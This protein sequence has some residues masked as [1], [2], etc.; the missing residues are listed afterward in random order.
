M[1]I[2]TDRILYDKGPYH[3][4]IRIFLSSTFCDLQEERSVI[5]NKV[6]T[7]LN[8]R[9][10]DKGIK[11]IIVDLRWGVTDEAARNG[12]VIEICLSEIQ[13]S[14]PYFAAIIGGRYGW[15]PTEDEIRHN[16]SLCRLYPNVLEDVRN[17]RSITE[18]EIQYAFLKDNLLER[19]CVFFF[20]ELDCV[21]DNYK[22]SGKTLEHLLNL[23]ASIATKAKDRLCTVDT[24]KTPETLRDIFYKRVCDLIDRDFPA[25]DSSVTPKWIF[26]IQNN[27]R[28]YES[29]LG[30]TLWKNLRNKFEGSLPNK[31]RRFTFYSSHSNDSTGYILAKL[32]F[33]K[34]P[35]DDMYLEDFKTEDAYR[36]NYKFIP[37]DIDQNINT[38][39]KFL[40]LFLYIYGHPAYAMNYDE[41][42]K[43]AINLIPSRPVVCIIRNLDNLPPAELAK[44]D[45]LDEL[46]EWIGFIIMCREASYDKVFNLLGIDD[47]E[48]E[49]RNIPDRLN[50]AQY[51]EVIDNRLKEWSKELSASQRIHLLLCPSFG[52]FHNLNMFLEIINRFGYYDRLDEVIDRFVRTRSD[53]EF[54]DIVLEMY[55]HELGRESVRWLLTRIA[56][57]NATADETELRDAFL[58]HF[59]VNALEWAAYECM[60]ENLTDKISACFHIS[61]AATVSA[62][63]ERY[64]L[65]IPGN[66]AEE[67]SGETEQCGETGLSEESAD[68]YLPTTADGDRKP[69]SKKEESD[70]VRNLPTSLP[71]AVQYAKISVE[72]MGNKRILQ[73]VRYYA[74][75]LKK[76]KETDLLNGFIKTLRET[77]SDDSSLTLLWIALT[78]ISPDVSFDDALSHI[79]GIL[80]RSQD[81]KLQKA[82]T[83][84]MFIFSDYISKMEI[85][86]NKLG[87][88]QLI[89]E[90]YPEMPDFDRRIILTVA[91]YKRRTIYDIP[92]LSGVCSFAIKWISDD[93][94]ARLDNFVHL[95]CGDFK[96][97][98]WNRNEITYIEF[99]KSFADF[100]KHNAAACGNTRQELLSVFVDKLAG[101]PMH[102]KA[103]YGNLML[104]LGYDVQ[105][106]KTAILEGTVYYLGMCEYGSNKQTRF[107]AKI[108]ELTSFPGYI[109][110]ASIRAL[111]ICN[112]LMTGHFAE[113]D[114]VSREGLNDIGAFDFLKF[115]FKGEWDEAAKLTGLI[116]IYWRLSSIDSKLSFEARL[117]LKISA[118][119]VYLYNEDSGFDTTMENLNTFWDSYIDHICECSNENLWSLRKLIAAVYAQRMG[120][121]DDAEELFRQACQPTASEVDDF[122]LGFDCDIK[123]LELL[124][125]MKCLKRNESPA[126]INQEVL[127]S[128][129]VVPGAIVLVYLYE[130]LSRLNPAEEEYSKTASLIESILYYRLTDKLISLI[131]EEWRKRSTKNIAFVSDQ[132]TL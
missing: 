94:P 105:S 62:L 118:L 22:D 116:T 102:L 12:E 70:F 82:F 75:I 10:N 72:D 13:K 65:D 109:P 131:P 78:E 128:I 29:I 103:K 33:E 49:V 113:A 122:R 115:I 23:R 63:A 32:S 117:A 93:I 25:G 104:R 46:N 88:L 27:N 119:L 36:P 87:L 127:E 99:L 8:K 112:Y 40:Q 50:I 37:V 1:N 56:E 52:R 60:L 4:E 47:K 76:L 58:R 98:V 59:N 14:R 71:D 92:D 16:K 79:I 6:A 64:G 73:L 81:P 130:K 124:N 55:E 106:A 97:E 44:L 24:F 54:T 108:K 66:Q 85:F 80:R 74:D 86:Q 77:D 90:V 34:I 21:D 43:T 57:N 107:L 19:Q 120:L 17:E 132:N 129:V 89:Y 5:V 114:A 84:T 51:L 35:L 91:E 96:D 26:S 28:E 83:S 53:K 45:F 111:E 3:V 31:Y 67:E 7:A 110:P 61:D 101:L 123:V 42:V 69:D 2:N 30:K 39:E 126:N 121:Y 125:V 95:L 38:A 18:M 11:I 41:L 100:F 48:Y 9:Y 15:Q 68:S 20:K